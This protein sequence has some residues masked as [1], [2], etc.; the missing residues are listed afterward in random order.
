MRKVSV[1]NI[2]SVERPCQ[3]T[4]LGCLWIAVGILSTTYH[5]RKGSLDR[6]M[7]SIVL[8]GIIAI[9]AGFFLL[10]GVGWAR[11][12]LLAWLAFHVVVSA[13]NSPRQTVPH[14]VLL[15]VVAYVLLGPPTRRYFRR[16]EPK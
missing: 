16:G 10:R 15:S 7:V 2:N 14:V 3:V 1:T 9:V 6:S 5:L 8:V 12:L 11:W 4:T 13:L